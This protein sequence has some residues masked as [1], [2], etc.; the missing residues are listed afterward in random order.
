MNTAYQAMV[1]VGVTPDDAIDILTHYL[2][3]ETSAHLMFL[4]GSE[5]VREAE[6][7]LA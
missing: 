7:A 3:A 1:A 6:R 2:V 5:V 4:N